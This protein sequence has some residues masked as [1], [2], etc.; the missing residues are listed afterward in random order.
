MTKKIKIM[1]TD[2]GL[3]GLSITAELVERIKRE[4]PF[5]EAEIIFFNCRPSNESGYDQLGSNEARAR[6]F[7]RALY[8]MYEKFKPDVIMI[9]CNTLS[10]IYEMCEFSKFPPVAVI[11]I[12]EDGVEKNFKLLSAKP[13]IQMIMF[14]TPT[15]VSSGAHKNIL[16][17]KGIA[18]ERL[19]Y[20]DCLSLPAV[21][22]RGAESDE[23][24]NM[25]ESFMRSGATKT[26]GQTFGISLL[27][28]HFAYSLSVFS[29][30]AREFEKFS[31]D[32]INPNSAMVDSFLKN[33]GSGKAAHAKTTVKCCTHTKI[34]SEIRQAM[35]PILGKISSDTAQA[36][37]NMLDTPDMF[38]I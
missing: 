19:H 2:S 18:S 8:A 25:V 17:G 29:E 26:K 10:A 1:T 34:S 16:I 31:G 11:G 22:S 38:S 5:D 37:L 24:K 14:G 13:E 7:S 27:C 15:T 20:Q 30:S 9:A 33:Y 3:G 12:I 35:F 6:V 4:K 32:I 36:F 28:T 23:V 21:I